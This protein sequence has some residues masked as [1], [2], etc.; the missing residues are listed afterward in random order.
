[1]R[2]THLSSITLIA[3]LCACQPEST[4]PV[5]AQISPTTSATTPVEAASAVP[6]SVVAA[7]AAVSSTPVAKPEKAT[8][9]APVLTPKSDAMSKVTAKVEATPPV[10]SK[11]PVAATVATVEKV[12]PAVTMPEVIAK[13]TA[14]SVTVLAEA[15]A[16][17]LAKKS[18][19][20]TCHSIEKK[21]VGPAWKDVAAKYRGDASAQSNLESKVAK[22]GKGAW[23]NMSMPANSPRV[24]EAD[25]HALVSFILSLK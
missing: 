12:A 17:Q 13:P 24:A 20:L 19:C 8:I 22:G 5:A 10:V 1:M 4:A 9:A 21:V 11:P 25:I 16:L 14:Q 2:L 3:L 15:D 7:S 18:G 23:G 6:T